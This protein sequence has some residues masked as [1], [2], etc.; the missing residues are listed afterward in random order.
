MLRDRGGSSINQQSSLHTGRFRRHPVVET[1]IF[2]SAPSERRLKSESF[3]HGGGNQASKETFMLM[4]CM[5]AWGRGIWR[6]D[7]S[8][9][10]FEGKGE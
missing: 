4:V 3:F 10:S 9:C 7:V 5:S 1:L 6:F 2:P 8:F